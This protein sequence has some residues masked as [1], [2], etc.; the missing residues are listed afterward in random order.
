MVLEEWS[1]SESLNGRSHPATREHLIVAE[2]LGGSL[3]KNR[4][5]HGAVWTRL[6][7][8]WRSPL[9]PVE[10]VVINCDC[11]RDSHDVKLH[12]INTGR[13]E[14][15]CQENLLYS[16]WV[17]RHGGGGSDNP[18][19]SK[20]TLCGIREA[21]IGRT[22]K[23]ILARVSEVVRDSLPVVLS[24]FRLVVFSK[25]CAHIWPL[26]GFREGEG[27]VSKTIS[28]LIELADGFIEVHV[29]IHEPIGCFR[30]DL[31]VCHLFGLP[32]VGAHHRHW[33]LVLVGVGLKSAQPRQ[34]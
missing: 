33:L 11:D 2:K 30:A 28:S 5:P 24:P 16:V 8:H 4:H 34:K 9:V 25:N 1:T 20:I 17:L 19:I 18:A 29:L 32:V 22:P 13:V 6:S 14:A 7:V 15:L 23:R 27:G 26:D 31:S 12:G 10:N 21:H 3:L